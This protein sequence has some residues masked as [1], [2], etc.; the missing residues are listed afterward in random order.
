MHNILGNFITL[1]QIIETSIYIT[2]WFLSDDDEIELTKQTNTLS[3]SF[4]FY[5][6]KNQWMNI[7]VQ[8][9]GLSI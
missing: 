6:H 2:S 5:S 4:M 9:A 3:M 1:I 7:S 8:F